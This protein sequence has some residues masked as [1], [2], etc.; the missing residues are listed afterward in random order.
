M[1]FTHLEHALAA[2]DGAAGALKVSQ[3]SSIAVLCCGLIEIWAAGGTSLGWC[4]KLE[5]PGPEAGGFFDF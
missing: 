2:T 4:P 3:S 5:L 1:S